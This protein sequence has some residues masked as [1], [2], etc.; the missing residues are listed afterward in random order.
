MAELEHTRNEVIYKR[1]IITD[2]PNAHA[3]LILKVEGLPENTLGV[4]RMKF[5]SLA[6]MVER[7]HQLN[8]IR[9][10]SWQQV[11]C[12]NE[13]EETTMAAV[14]EKDRKKELVEK[15]AEQFQQLNED[16]KMFI[17]GYML[18]IQQ[19]RQRTT[20]QPQTA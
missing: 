11:T 13:K 8:H 3:E 16:N 10:S 18:G 9:Q 19:E 1:E 7:K 4:L 20:P 12:L 14:E 6:E 15:T 2:E 5:N 17:L